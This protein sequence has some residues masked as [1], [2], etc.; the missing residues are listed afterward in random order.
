MVELRVENTDYRCIGPRMIEKLMFHL[1]YECELA[2]IKLPWDAAVRRLHP[3]SKGGAATQ[4]LVKLRTILL[5]EGHIVPPKVRTKNKRGPE[6]GAEIRGFIRPEDGGPYETRVV[7]WDEK[8]EDLSKNIENPDI[9]R[10]SGRYPRKN[11][12]PPKTPD[13]IPRRKR[14]CRRDQSKPRSVSSTPESP[15]V[16]L[17]VKLKLAP[18]SLG[19]FRD[20]TA[21][22]QNGN[23]HQNMRRLRDRKVAEL[24]YEVDSS[25]DDDSNESEGEYK[26]ESGSEEGEHASGQAIKR[27]YTNAVANQGV[28]K[29]ARE[30]AHK[31]AEEINDEVV[32]EVIDEEVDE[33]DE[34]VADDIYEVPQVIDD[35]VSDDILDEISVYSLDS[36]ESSVQDGLPIVKSESNTPKAKTPVKNTLSFEDA[37]GALAE[38]TQV[39]AFPAFANDVAFDDS[40]GTYSSAHLDQVPDSQSQYGY[41]GHSM[42]NGRFFSQPPALSKGLASNDLYGQN[43]NI[44]THPYQSYIDYQVQV[45][46]SY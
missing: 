24:K 19:L 26:K 21:R 46:A 39:D 6:F 20:D 15:K 37:V 4:H 25:Q 27:E 38:P 35:D 17:M 8:I 9:I 16:C 5:T 18:A 22:K 42:I 45:S 31:V 30:V 3:G 34:E 23:G 12:K 41:Q 36:A 33:A 40:L 44:P 1:Q 7:G 2:G 28:N 10:G 43:A 32:D 11:K 29:V 13:S 14:V